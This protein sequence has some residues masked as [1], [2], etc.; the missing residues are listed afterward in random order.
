MD[1][2]AYASSAGQAEKP[3]HRVSGWT[4]RE[5]KIRAR[6]FEA[7]TRAQRAEQRVIFLES[8]LAKLREGKI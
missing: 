5:M 1:A 2:S 7:E 3:K 6:I 4:R 8:Q